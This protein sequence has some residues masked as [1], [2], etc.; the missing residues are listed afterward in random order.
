MALDQTHCVPCQIGAPTLTPPQI[1]ALKTQISPDWQVAENKKLIREFKFK[2][3][4]AAIAFINQVANIAESE[5][6]HPNIH[7]TNWNRIQ[8]ELYTHK[9]NG[10]HQNDFILAAKIDKLMS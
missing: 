7:L 4:K 6:H 5:G 10:L 3:F 9:I 8:I 1:E 2:D